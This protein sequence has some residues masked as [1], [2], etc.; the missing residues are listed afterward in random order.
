MGIVGM[1]KIPGK[2]K[3]GCMPIELSKLSFMDQPFQNCD[4][5][6]VPMFQPMANTVEKENLHA[7][8]EMK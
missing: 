7:T 5:N 2:M 4:Q 6:N 3:V 1:V 8:I